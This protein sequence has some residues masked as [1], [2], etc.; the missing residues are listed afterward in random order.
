M[1]L[2]FQVRKGKLMSMLLKAKKNQQ[3][4]EVM[5]PDVK[6]NYCSPP[7]S[8]SFSN[9]SMCRRVLFLLHQSNSPKYIQLF[10][11]INEWINESGLLSIVILHAVKL[12]RNLVPII[13]SDSAVVY[14]RLKRTVSI[15]RIK[16]WTFDLDSHGTKRQRDIKMLSRRYKPNLPVLLP[17][18]APPTWDFLSLVIFLTV[19]SQSTL[20]LINKRTMGKSREYFVTNIVVTLFVHKLPF[21]LNWKCI[22]VWE[23]NSTWLRWLS[24]LIQP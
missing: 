12:N 1:G 15:C 4:S 3:H 23:L 10:L 6:R 7:C 17:V 24:V 19:S 14:I 8:W 22:S 5:Q 18:S 16:I 21:S 2:V 11:G 20:R 9:Y 13:I